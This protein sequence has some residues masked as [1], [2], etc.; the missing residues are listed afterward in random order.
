MNESCLEFF[1]RTDADSQPCAASPQSRLNRACQM[2]VGRESTE[3]IKK[4]PRRKDRN[5]WR[6]SAKR[7]KRVLRAS[8]PR[9][10]NSSTSARSFFDAPGETFAK[11]NRNRSGPDQKP[12]CVPHEKARS[13]LRAFVSLTSSGDS[14]GADSSTAHRRNRHIPD[15][16]I[17]VRNSRSQARNSHKGG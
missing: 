3:S 2:H 13:K 9:R 12:C 17:A 1:I 14:S 11:R 7:S 15:R 16:N 10:K 6:A 5:A 4:W 8:K